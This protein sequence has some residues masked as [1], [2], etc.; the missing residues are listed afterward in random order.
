MQEFIQLGFRGQFRQ[1]PV[2]QTNLVFPF[3]A[4]SPASSQQ[5]GGHYGVTGGE[6]QVW[7]VRPI[8][9]RSSLN[10]SYFEK[11]NY[12]NGPLWT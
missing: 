3:T 1:P 4:L 8:A 10:L 7:N 9:F 6:L 12:H 11:P 5:S 2:A